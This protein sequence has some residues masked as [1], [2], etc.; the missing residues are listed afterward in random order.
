M[1]TKYVSKILGIGLA[2]GLVFALLPLGP[3]A[4]GEMEWG[5]VTTPSWA[6]EVIEPGSDIY[7]YAVGP[8]GDTIIATGAVN[9]IDVLGESIVGLS[10][11]FN[12]RTGELTF[13][14]ISNTVFEIEGW[15]KG[16][17]C[18]LFGDYTL[19]AE[20]QAMQVWVGAITGEITGHPDPGNDD[21]KMTFSGYMYG[22]NSSVAWGPGDTIS[23]DISPTSDIICVNNWSISNNPWIEIAPF[24]PLFQILPGGVFTEP[25]VW[26]SDDGGVTWSNLTAD[27]QDA[28]NL[29][30]PFIQFAFGGTAIAPDDEDWAVVAGT[31]FDPA[32]SSIMLPFGPFGFPP[33]VPAVVATKDGGSG[34]SF[35]GDVADGSAGS[36]M[37][38]IYDVDVSLEV[39][40]IHNIAV[41][42]IACDTPVTGMEPPFS[43]P[44]VT[45]VYGAIY[46]LEAGTWLT[47]T[48]EDT[49]TYDGWDDGVPCTG[50]CLPWTGGGAPPPPPP[51]NI[52]AGVGAC[53]FSTNFDLDDT[54][55]SLTIDQCG[56]P[57]LQ[58]GLWG[59][60]GTWNGEAAFPDAVE[61]D[62]DGNALLTGLA[63]RGMGLALPADYD[64]SDSGDR[65]VFIYID[66]YNT[67]TELTGGW[68][69]RIDDSAVSPTCGPSGDPVLASIAVHGDADT[70]KM[71]VGTYIG[72]ENAS[73]SSPGNPVRF[74]DCAGV[75]VYHT[76]ELD[77]CCPQWDAACKDPSGPYGA[78]VAYT[79]D[80][81]KAYATTSGALDPFWIG[82]GDRWNDPDAADGMDDISEFWGGLSDESA[83]SVSLDDGVSFNQLGLI[84]TDIDWVS[85]MAVCPDCGVI[86]MS[87]INHSDTIE[88][89]PLA[90]AEGG[91]VEN[92][93][94]PGMWA[95]ACSDTFEWVEI[96]EDVWAFVTVGCTYEQVLS[97]VASCDSIWRSYDDGDTWERV[98]HGAWSESP[99]DAILLR[100]PCDEIEEC[101]TVYMGIQNSD[102]IQYTRD[103][104]QCWSAPPRTKI[105]IQDIAIESEDTIYILNSAGEVSKSTA[106]GRRWSDAVDVGTDSGHT[107]A[108]CCTEDLVVVGGTDGDSVAFSDDGGDSWTSMDDI[109]ETGEIHIACDT[110]CDG[111]IYAALSGAGIYRGDVS[112]GSWSTLNAQPYNYY[113][114][115][116][117]KSDGTLYA[118]TNQINVDTTVTFPDEC[119]DR[120]VGPGLG[121][122]VYSGVAR[123]LTPCETD[124]CGE[125]D[126]DYLF[127][128]LGTIDCDTG[129]TYDYYPTEW[130]DMEP[131]S[132]RICGCTTS[133]T[134]SVLYAIDYN[135]YWV[136]DGSNGT[137]WSYEDCASKK[138]PILTS[139]VNGA[140]ID[141][142]DCDCRAATF[143]LEWQRMC[144]ACSY[145]IEIMDAD[146]NVI[147]SWDDEELTGDPPVLYVGP[148][149]VERLAV[150]GADYQWHVRE[151]NTETG[152]CV[153]SPWSATWTFTVAA[154]AAT[155]L[156]L[157]APDNGEMGIPT[158]NVAFSWT[159][160]PRATSYSIVLS[161]NSDL[162]GA[163]A[164]EE[165]SGTAYQYTG[166]LSEGT[167]Y[168]WQVIAWID[169]SV[170]TTSSVGAFTTLTTP[171][172]AP[173]PVVVEPT[174][175]PVIE[176]PPVQ[177]I[178]PG[179]IYAVIAIGAALL[180]VVIVLIVRTR[181]PS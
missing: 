45:W 101:C 72:W 9:T 173:P 27:V 95:Y 44:T 105:L 129:A 133:G 55:V 162:S 171:A 3:V 21:D 49:T 83:F 146:G 153:H 138:G 161:P 122:E 104:G 88:G 99:T 29:P 73:G 28:A 92:P 69:F 13:T 164:S 81:D 4:A 78:V 132:L 120:I 142:D 54:I 33:G 14:K 67:V 23:Y 30:G 148:S 158:A 57:Y 111:T 59:A 71:M 117:G 42:G 123:N 115:V 156:N 159:S 19:I 139:P 145:D 15:F 64:G 85:D 168:Y 174:P 134:N 151:A 37:M 66:A 86:Y 143:S 121:D 53:E 38:R 118:A 34:F 80:G 103:C 68:V 141:C 47:G 94:V 93:A 130:F 52:T 100:L 147:I 137:I 31:I 98:N 150:C 181:R 70:G 84:D 8:D 127:A 180:V 136:V 26:K 140:L 2:I 91:W 25:R 110:L 170:L 20:F 41:A 17:A 89:C 60:S 16:D 12:I 160:V 112:D 43:F 76:E 152:E 40:D 63:L 56:V 32:Y 61:I 6:D 46:R 82:L 166:A 126:W 144:L 109:G 90:A 22:D 131:S 18:Y 155:P 96:C 79:P 1:K 102:D 35:A 87:T 165:L 113:G 107:I 39:D 169:G 167:P 77:F 51:C 177:Q 163:L 125:E 36:R 7:D 116:V 176:I 11:S 10:G 178:T 154:G 135:P 179:W 62:A 108:A 119:A 97:E 128:G 24:S 106:Y 65:T 149:D 172:P 5:K 74:Y 157:L 114:I 48:W 175:A 50:G 124:C 75:A 58:S